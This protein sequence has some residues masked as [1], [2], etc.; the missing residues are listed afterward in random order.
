MT[1]AASQMNASPT[2]FSQAD[3]TDAAAL[4]PLTVG[5]W[6]RLTDAK[7]RKHNINLAAGVEFSTHRGQ[8]SHDHIIGSPEGIIIESSMGH[9]YQVFR[10]LLHEYVVSM[11]RGAAIVYPK[12]AAQI[13]M[14]A[15]IFPGARV[16][17][18]GAGSGSLTQYL[19]RAIGPEGHLRSFEHR[20]DFAEVCQRNVQ[21]TFGDHTPNWHLIQQDVRESKIGHRADRI[22]LDMVDP[23]TCVDFAAA[24]L[25]PGGI[26]C[27]YV[28]TTPQ[29][30]LFVETIRAH[31]GFT[32]PRAWENMERVWH[33]EGL[34][35]RPSHATSGHTAFLAT[36]R[37]LAPG[38]QAL[39]RTRRP[40]PGA[41]G[42]DYTGPMPADLSGETLNTAE[43]SR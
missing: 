32:E 17:E 22:I 36:A 24:H 7:G 31:G 40:A 6:V 13:L 25:V 34:A 38:Q 29:L 39:P 15:D 23:W 14:M 21:Q 2:D 41:Y 12:D 1:D 42:P 37:R 8:V 4:R 19:L 11:P 43:R 35:V 10:P 27:A 5:E 16:L 30:S 20:D 26:A 28:T 18:V 33:V 3:N 9:Q